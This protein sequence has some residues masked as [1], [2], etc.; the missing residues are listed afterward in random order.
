MTLLPFEVVSIDCICWVEILDNGTL[1]HISPNSAVSDI[2]LVAWNWPW[3]EYLYHRN[4]QMLQ[5]SPRPP[6]TVI[7]HW[8][9]WLRLRYL[10]DFFKAPPVDSDEQQSWEAPARIWLLLPLERASS[11]G[12]TLLFPTSFFSPA[13]HNQLQWPKYVCHVISCSVFLLLDTLMLLPGMPVTS[14]SAWQAP[15]HLPK[16]NSVLCPVWALPMPP[17]HTGS[18]LCLCDLYVFSLR[19]F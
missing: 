9:H 11:L 13:T 8:Y 10:H 4:W 1:L 17:A 16:L 12:K 3:H 14:L 15:V 18:P 19:G 7:Q 5:I 2:P 6:T